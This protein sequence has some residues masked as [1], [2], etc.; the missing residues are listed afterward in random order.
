[1][2]ELIRK[3][4]GMLSSKAEAD[5]GARIRRVGIVLREVHQGGREVP[6]ERTARLRITSRSDESAPCALVEPIC[7]E[8]VTV[9]ACSSN[10]GSHLLVVKHGQHTNVGFLGYRGFG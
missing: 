2:S 1:M 6:S 4:L 10:G 9:C 8:H 3:D 5:V 7:H